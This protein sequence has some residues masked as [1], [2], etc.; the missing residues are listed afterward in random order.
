MR[1]EAW[2]VSM[3]SSQEWEELSLGRS[4][5]K[6]PACCAALGY[7][8]TRHV[9][10]DALV[11]ILRFSTKSCYHTPRTCPRLS[12]LV[13]P[14]PGPHGHLCCHPAERLPGWPL[15][16]RAHLVLVAWSQPGKAGCKQ[17]THLGV[18][19]DMEGENM[20]CVE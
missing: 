12:Q 17:R 19:K 15:N 10:D 14:V 11:A 4:G 20:G 8:G 9:T 13:K 7:V 3:G 6:I 5:L 2:W 1:K 18:V 16:S